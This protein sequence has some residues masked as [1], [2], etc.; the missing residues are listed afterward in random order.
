[1]SY[2][3][4]NELLSLGLV[5]AEDFGKTK[6][7]RLTPR[8]FKYFNMS[9]KEFKDV[10]RDSGAVEVQSG[11]AKT[12]KLDRVEASEQVKEE[13]AKPKTK[14]VQEGDRDAADTFFVE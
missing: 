7:L 14:T 3:H 11:P 12:K 4:V 6:M 1:K 8:F 5:Q 10:F 2:G 9:K 13:K